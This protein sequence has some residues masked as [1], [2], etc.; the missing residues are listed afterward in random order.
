MNSNSLASLVA[1]LFLRFVLG[2]TFLWAGLAKV[3]ESRDYSGE[4]AALLARWQVTSAADS[5]TPPASEPSKADAA[6]EV[7]A[8]PADPAAPAAEQ[9]KDAPT[10][11]TEAPAT[12]AP[13]HLPNLYMIATMLYHGANPAPRADGTPAR[14]IVPAKAAEG[15]TPVML[16]WAASITELAAGVCVLI[17]FFTRLASLGLASVMGV[18]IW[19]TQIGP[20]VAS[21]TGKFGF[22]PEYATFDPAWRDLLWQMA[23]GGSAL[24]LMFAGAGMM[25]LDRLLFH[26]PVVVVK[27]VAAAAATT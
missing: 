12:A 10:A 2:V 11:T 23:L 25:S 6:K 3:M 26:R 9:P 27:P 24:A 18:A 16:A 8:K 5:G 21:G 13:V 22:L 7:P 20:A 1:P 14:P 4:D 17:G 15:R 19:L